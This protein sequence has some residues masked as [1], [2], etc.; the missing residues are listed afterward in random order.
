MNDQINRQN[1]V[2]NKSPKRTIV[3]SERKKEENAKSSS[4]TSKPTKSNPDIEFLGS[5]KVNRDEKSTETIHQQAEYPKKTIEIKREKKSPAKSIDR[6]RQHSSSMNSTT[7]K[8]KTDQLSSSHE[9]DK[10]NVVQPSSPIC[11]ILDDDS[12]PAPLVDKKSTEKKTNESEKTSKSSKRSRE[13]EKSHSSKDKT[14]S[15]HSEAKR[16]RL[17][18]GLFFFNIFS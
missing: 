16:K 6:Q 10:S 2:Q 9:N 18:D 8:T 13:P 3:I 14:S 12:D 17:S 4:K 1:S 15:E 7:E 5:K 11:V